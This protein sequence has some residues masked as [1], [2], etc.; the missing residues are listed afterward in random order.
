MF[1]KLRSEADAEVVVPL[2]HRVIPNL[3]SYRTWIVLP[4]FYISFEPVLCVH[5]HNHTHFQ[6]WGER[7]DE[8]QQN[9]S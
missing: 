3:T 7:T 4:R 2:T 9:F 6:E 8:Q 5:T 1:Q